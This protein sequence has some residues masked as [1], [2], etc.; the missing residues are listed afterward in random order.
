MELHIDGM[1]T[2][3]WMG[4]TLNFVPSPKPARGQR[5]CTICHTA[6]A[7]GLN[8]KGANPALMLRP[9]LFTCNL[10]LDL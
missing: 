8:A 4:P 9:R 6:P 7:A 5:G 1:L 3:G 2:Q 10:V